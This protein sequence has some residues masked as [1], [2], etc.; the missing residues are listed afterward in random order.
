MYHPEPCAS[1]TYVSPRERAPRFLRQDL[2]LRSEGISGWAP[3]RSI[4][5][6]ACADLRA[7]WHRAHRDH[8][9]DRPRCCSSRKS[10]LRRAL[11]SGS[12][13]AGSARAGQG[14]YARERW[15]GPSRSRRA[16][17]TARTA[18]R[19][20]LQ[21]YLRGCTSGSCWHTSPGSRQPRRTV[22][23]AR[24]GAVLAFFGFGGPHL[25][26]ATGSGGSSC[27][28][29]RR[30]AVRRGRSPSCNSVRGGLILMGRIGLTLEANFYLYPLARR[31]A[32]NAVRARHIG[33]SSWVTLGSRSASAPGSR[34]CRFSPISRP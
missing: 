24:T 13:V 22:G 4:V 33:F 15:G 20:G 32:Q 6:P 14:G 29:W 28:R 23:A 16:P 30:R 8:P 7:A 10:R 25:R 11:P 3:G 31:A 9:A 18:C 19:S 26:S 12:R 21:A 1:P 5:T 17:A 27:G 34:R 2:S